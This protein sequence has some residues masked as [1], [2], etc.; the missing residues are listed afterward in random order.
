MT[1]LF[2]QRKH[3]ADECEKWEEQNNLGNGVLNTIAFL[4]KEGLLD[5]EK[6]KEMFPL[7]INLHQ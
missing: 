2:S 6:I 4:S 7:K 3:L 1:L 5:E